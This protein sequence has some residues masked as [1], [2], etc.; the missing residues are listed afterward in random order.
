MK[1]FF[2]SVRLTQSEREK[3]GEEKKFPRSRMSV[4][5]MLQKDE[6]S[7]WSGSREKVKWNIQN[8][9]FLESDNRGTRRRKKCGEILCFFSMQD[10]L[11]VLFWL[12]AIKY[13]LAEWSEIEEVWPRKSSRS[14]EIVKWRAKKSCC[15]FL[16]KQKNKEEKKRKE[17]CAEE[18]KVKKCEKLKAW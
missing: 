17:L 8:K 5:K 2:F 18:E 1:K 14:R 16:I 4:W 9:I 11:S 6:H 13:Y 10:Q 3:C 7:L 15:E 12:D